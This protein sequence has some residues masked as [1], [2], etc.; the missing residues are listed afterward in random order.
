MY[1]G[2]RPSAVAG[3][4]QPRFATCGIIVLASCLVLSGARRVA[5]ETA[6]GLGTV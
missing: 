6:N 1:L 4:A 2:L 5:S 3:V